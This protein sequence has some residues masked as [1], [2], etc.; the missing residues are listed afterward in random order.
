V[1]MMQ[2]RTLQRRYAE[3]MRAN[4]AKERMSIDNRDVRLGSE[5]ISTCCL[6]VQSAT[7]YV[8]D[9]DG[10]LRLDITIMNAYLKLTSAV[11]MLTASP[12]CWRTR[13]I[14]K[15][16]KNPLGGRSSQGSLVKV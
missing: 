11:I 1:S 15:V 9:R 16:T 10:Y 7:S 12:R 3:P 13:Q 5:S 4:S 2:T 8:N 14:T 6:L